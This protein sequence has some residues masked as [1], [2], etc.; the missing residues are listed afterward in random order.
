[1]TFSF[2]RTIKRFVC[3]LIKTLGCKRRDHTVVN[4][5]LRTASAVPDNTMMTFCSETGDRTMTFRQ[6]R[7][8]A[9]QLANLFKDRGY[10]KVGFKYFVCHSQ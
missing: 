9:L 10:K 4:L 3:I 8:K 6:C 1:M 5:I 2:F 7:E